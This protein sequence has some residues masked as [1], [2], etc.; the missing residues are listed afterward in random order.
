MS[1]DQPL[2][3]GTCI[4][5]GLATIATVLK[6]AGH[7]VSLQVFTPKTPLEDT[8]RTIIEELKPK[9]FCFTAVS[10]QFP[11]VSRIAAQV[12]K[13]D[14]SIYVIV[15]GAHPSLAPE[16]S[17]ACPDIDG[18]CIGEGETGIL[19]LAS[20]LEAGQQPHMV[21]NFWLKQLEKGIKEKN[22]RIP[23]LD[24]LD[25]LPFIDRELWRR[26]IKQPTHQAAVLLGRGCPNHCT[27]CSNHALKRLASGRYVRFRSPNNVL[28]EIFEIVQDPLINHIY[29][30]IET[31]TA[32]LEYCYKL[33]RKL[34]A[35]NHN[36]QDPI[37]FSLN[38]SFT[39]K[40]ANNSQTVNHFF[41][42]L[43]EANVV[44]LKLGLESGSER[45][46]N[47]VLKRP[48]YSNEE[49]ISFC[50]QANHY[51]IGIS[52]YLLIGLPE[53]TPDDFRKTVEVTREC[54]PE[55]TDLSIFYPYPGTALYLKAQKENFFNPSNLDHKHERHF[56]ALNLS[57]FPKRNILREFILINY[58]VFRG[59]WSL[60][61][62]FNDVFYRT[63]LLY[64]AIA[65]F[66][67]TLRACIRFIVKNKYPKL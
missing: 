66:Y 25:R 21:P 41:S 42:A 36:R 6:V 54:A 46:R 56:V 59:R 4:H 26:W 24:D 44:T 15:G 18:I 43:K 23:F 35:F 27:Y 13:L 51:G 61:R 9:L 65:P 64:P 37:K 19:V 60:A 11:I 14:P 53:E 20:Q 10:T 50:K 38:C 2:P 32:N 49:I 30:E 28:D 16:E 1:V 48:K 67:I 33:C 34:T 57:G 63:S 40:L 31:I 45:I 39:S 52:T 58:K 47:E 12:K 3:S 29:L 17:L 7:N 22:S 62:R 5:F 55:M 8:L